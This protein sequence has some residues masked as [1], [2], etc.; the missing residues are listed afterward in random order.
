MS[1]VNNVELKSPK[2]ILEAYVFLYQ[3]EEWTVGIKSKNYTGEGQSAEVSKEAFKEID[4][5]IKELVELIDKE[6]KIRD[7]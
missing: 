2:R 4:R 1:E 6:V 7:D 3:Q 5:K